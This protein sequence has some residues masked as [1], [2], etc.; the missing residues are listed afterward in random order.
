[1]KHVLPL[2]S[3]PAPSSTFRIF[4]SH[5]LLRR[6]TTAI[7]VVALFLLS[8]GNLLAQGVTT[9]GVEGV[10]TDEAGGPLVGASV[11]AVHVPSGTTYQTVART[12][13]V[14]TIP[15]MRVG[16][17]YTVTASIIGYAESSEQDITVALGQDIRLD[18]RLSQEAIVLE[19]LAV[20]A[21]DDDVMNASRTGAATF[22]PQE[23]VQTQPS[24]KRTTRD[25]IKND[26]R[27]DGNYAF[28]GRNWLYNNITLD[29]SYFS[30]PFGLDDPAPGGQTAADP[31]PY[32]AVEQVQVA[33]APFDVRQSG[34][35]GANVNTVTKS[36]TN[37]LRGGVSLYWEP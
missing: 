12:G 2:Y 35:T 25:L 15:G 16:G 37:T 23:M 3:F 18:F 36:G 27:G 5:S 14:F 7:T 4:S 34:F 30:N 19:A 21:A 20:E 10:V 11:T 17:P 8:S 32:D 1:M 31:V 22:I 29:G 6:S 13:G 26:P 33:I 28:A 24:V 9:G